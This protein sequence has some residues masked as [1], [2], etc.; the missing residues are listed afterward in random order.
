MKILL[1][2]IAI[3][4]GV[5]FSLFT[6]MVKIASAEV[7]TG[8]GGGNRIDNP[9]KAT[10]LADLFNNIVSVAIELGTILAVLGIMYG[11]YLYV[12]AQGNEEKLGAAQKTITWALVGTA[13]LLG[14]R[15]IM[16]AIRSTVE[17][18]G[19]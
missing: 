1:K 13:V 6:I 12:T 3:H 14:A 8:M 19:A 11:G 7:S 5:F 17:Q 10:S 18:L 4:G 9:I 15:T 2:K 16:A